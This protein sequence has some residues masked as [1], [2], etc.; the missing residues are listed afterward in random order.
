MLDK[1]SSIIC[2]FGLAAAAPRSPYRH[3]ELCGIAL[4]KYRRG[5][6]PFFGKAPRRIFV[7]IAAILVY[8]ATDAAADTEQGKSRFARALKSAMTEMK[9]SLST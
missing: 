6:F 2:A 1:T 4:N 8:K 3:L 7:Y 9:G 5:A